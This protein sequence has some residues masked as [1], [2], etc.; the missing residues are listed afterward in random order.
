MP[1]FFLFFQ[2]FPQLEQLQQQFCDKVQA[3]SFDCLLKD[4]SV[5]SV[6][7]D[8]DVPLG[9]DADSAEYEFSPPLILEFPH[10]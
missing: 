2:A 7:P 3:Q 5:R 10:Q 6:V 8:P 9:C 1:H 4:C